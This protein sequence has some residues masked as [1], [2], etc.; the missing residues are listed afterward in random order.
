MDYAEEFLG[1]ELEVTVDRQ[2]GS[3]HPE[4][5]KMVYPVNYGY[6][7]GTLAPDGEEVDAYVLGVGDP[8]EKFKGVCIALIHRKNDKDDKLVVVPKGEKYT[9]TKIKE[10]VN[11]QEKYFDSDI[12]LG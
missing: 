2:L 8:V 6:I 9:T 1:K 12:I 10:L 7:E 11:F 4:Y 3:V 5:R